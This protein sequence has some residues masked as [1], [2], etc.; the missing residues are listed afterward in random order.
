MSPTLYW[1]EAGKFVF[2]ALFMISSVKFC[3]KGIFALTSESCLLGFLESKNL[4]RI[5]LVELELG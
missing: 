5:V 4:G 3:H 2:L 1:L